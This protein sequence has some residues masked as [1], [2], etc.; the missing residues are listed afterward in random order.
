MMLT[1][2]SFPF[3]KRQT[4][5]AGRRMARMWP[6]SHKIFF[7]NRFS[8]RRVYDNTQPDLD[9]N[10]E[11]DVLVNSCEHHLYKRLDWGRVEFG[12]PA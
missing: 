10:R 12:S 11:L 4:L 8:S 6:K 2:Q 7:A 3:W 5:V 1:E 9:T